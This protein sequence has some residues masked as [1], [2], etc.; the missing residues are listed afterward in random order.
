M[1]TWL[2]FLS[3][4]GAQVRL[5]GTPEVIG[6]PT[7][8]T[9]G[10][11]S[12][13]SPLTDYGLI[14]VTGEDAASFLHNQLTNDVEHLGLHEARLAGYCTPKGRLLASFLMWKTADG[15]ML[16]V[17]R[18][19]QPTVQ[20]RL[21][22]FVLRSKAKLADVTEQHV[23]LGL[24][25]DA[26]ALGGLFPTVPTAPYEKADADAG[27]LI[28]VADAF[29]APRYLWITDAATA[30]QAWPAL[31]K[32]LSPTGSNAWKLADIH[33]GIPHITQPTQEQFVPQMVN[34]DVIGGVNFKKG[35]YPGQEIVARTH[36][37]GKVKRR[38][39]LASIEAGDV[40]AGSEIFSNAE[41]EQPC[42][43]V[44]NAARNAQGGTDCLVEIKS[45]L[46]GEATVHAGSV[47]GPLLRFAPLPYALSDGE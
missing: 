29:G 33:A 24:S 14:A 27:T 30:E 35:C 44:V 8:T 19:I 2:Q 6:F 28:H 25:G 31:N 17:S 16:M 7:R 36:Y 3:E 46:A 20:K 12:F 15:I 37:L 22:M 39:L 21:H 32:S 9:A 1:N 38:M 45:A 47:E 42:G 41:P 40:K 34:F 18:D 10:T 5:E 23:L 13:V 26:T 43:M 11:S 4:N